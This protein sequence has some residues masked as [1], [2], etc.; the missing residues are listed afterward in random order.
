MGRKNSKKRENE[1]RSGSHGQGFKGTVEVTRSGIG[2][3]TVENMPVDIL[4]RQNDLNT[5]LHGDK[6]EVR[7]KEMRHGGKRMQ[8]VVTRVLTRK[9][10][11]FMGKMQMNENFAFFIA[12]TDRP[13]PDI[14]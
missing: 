7:V 14:F 13:M 4:V 12:E 1:K 2:Y 10:S 5:A 6:V 3:V 9:Q 8:G 11:E